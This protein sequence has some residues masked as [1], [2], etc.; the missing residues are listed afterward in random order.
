MRLCVIFRSTSPL[1]LS[2]LSLYGQFFYQEEEE[3]VEI[4]TCGFPLVVGL[5]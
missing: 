3:I 2:P 4:E 5:G 1:P